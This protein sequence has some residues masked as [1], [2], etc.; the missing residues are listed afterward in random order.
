MLTWNKSLQPNKDEIIYE[1]KY[2][3]PKGWFN[4]FERI[5]D[6][7]ATIIVL[8]VS[9]GLIVDFYNYSAIYDAMILIFS[10]PTYLSLENW[11]VLGLYSILIPLPFLLVLW[12]FNGLFFSSKKCDFSY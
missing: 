8:F 12:S 9:L 7:I 4:R 3:F 5:V 1:F 11:L 10:Y 2:S 6:R